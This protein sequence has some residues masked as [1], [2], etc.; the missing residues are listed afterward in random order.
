V[1]Y[2][3]RVEQCTALSCLYSETGRGGE[4]FRRR[5]GIGKVRESIVDRKRERK[6]LK[7]G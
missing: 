5:R 3:V 1:L 7:R 2:I 4:E 6:S